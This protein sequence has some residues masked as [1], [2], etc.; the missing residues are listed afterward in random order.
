MFEKIK[1]AWWLLFTPLPSPPT[2]KEIQ[3]RRKENAER[4]IKVILMRD[5]H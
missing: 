5:G 3:A 1:R 4:I 2:E